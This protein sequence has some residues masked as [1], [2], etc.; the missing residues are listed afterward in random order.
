MIFITCP[1][2]FKVPLFKK[3]QV[4]ALVSWI[5][6]YPTASFLL[7]CEDLCLDSS[8]KYYELFKKMRAGGKLKYIDSVKGIDG[9]PYISGI[10]DE[11]FK[12][13]SDDE[14]VV[15]INSDIILFSDFKRTLD[16]LNLKISKKKRILFTGSR[17]DWSVPEEIDFLNNNWDKKIRDQVLRCGCQHK[18]T[19]KDYFV[20]NKRIW[21]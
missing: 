11:A 5:E 10:F 8:E 18:G 9:V 7:F 13:A 2:S 16:Y 17:W 4:N 21:W 3:I 12:I 15:Y 20:V 19:G 14:Y 6:L 1:K